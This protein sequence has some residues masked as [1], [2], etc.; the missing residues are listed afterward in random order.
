MEEQVWSD[1]DIFELLRDDFVLISLYVDDRTPLPEDDWFTFEFQNGRRKEIQS[2]GDYWSTF[3][4]LN[5]GAVS[6]PYYVLLSAD[7]EI[8]APP[9]Q[10]T[11]AETYAIWLQTGLDQMRDRG[12]KTA[13]V[14]PFGD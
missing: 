13:D 14:Q 12:F 10:N 5:F 4:N 6:Q 2:V 3:Q 1:P 8:L 7:L 11:D 9:V